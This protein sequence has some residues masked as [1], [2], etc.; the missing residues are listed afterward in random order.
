MISFITLEPAANV[1]SASSHILPALRRDLSSPRTSIATSAP[2]DIHACLSRSVTEAGKSGQ[3]FRPRHR[4]QR[5]DWLAGVGGL[6][7]RDDVAKYPFERSHRFP[8]IQPNS[9]RRDYLRSSCDGGRRS[10]GLA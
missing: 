9:D 3:F 10:S 7:L 6:A 4:S 5:P 2:A 8:V 1:S